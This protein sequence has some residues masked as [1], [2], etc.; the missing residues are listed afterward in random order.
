MPLTEKLEL[1]DCKMGFERELDNKESEIWRKHNYQFYLFIF[2]LFVSEIFEIKCNAVAAGILVLDHFIR[3]RIAVAVN[4][5][6]INTSQHQNRVTKVLMK[7]SR[8]KCK[9][10]M[11]IC[12]ITITIK[13]DD[14]FENA[15]VE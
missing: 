1:W 6:D 14:E 2:R 7:A 5:N 15:M 3:V 8:I 9:K 10:G 13:I 11:P 12:G 4:G